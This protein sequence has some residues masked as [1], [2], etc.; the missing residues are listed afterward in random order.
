MNILCTWCGETHN[1][2]EDDLEQWEE[3]ISLEEVAVYDAVTCKHCESMIP[4]VKQ[5]FE[6]EKAHQEIRSLRSTI[7]NLEIENDNLKRRLRNESISV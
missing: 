1:Y 3:D 6:L 5:I 4:T 2:Q 7:E